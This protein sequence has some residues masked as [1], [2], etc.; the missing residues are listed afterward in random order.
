MLVNERDI[1]VTYAQ[2]QLGI[3]SERNKHQTFAWS[4][5]GG[6]DLLQNIVLAARR[7]QQLAREQAQ[8]QN[9]RYDN[10]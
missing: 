8:Q 6:G 1:S 5:M 2:Q 9:Q 3:T 7:T 10:E 4:K